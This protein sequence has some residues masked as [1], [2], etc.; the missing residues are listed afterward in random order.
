MKLCFDIEY[1]TTWGEE[2]RVLG[3][4]PELGGESPGE[5]LPL[6]TVDGI[7]WQGE[8]EAA[9]PCKRE[10][11]YL[12]QIY[13]DGK[14]VRTEWHA[15][16]RTLHLHDNEGQ[17]YRLVD[18]WKDLPE[19]ACF[20]TSAFT[21]SLLAR[22]KSGVPP[23]VFKRG[24]QVKA[25]APCIGS[26]YVLGLCG[27]QPALGNWNADRALLMNDACFPEWQVALDAQGLRYPLEYKFVLYSLKTRRAV[28]WEEGSNR[29]LDEP[30]LG[31]NEMLVIGD[32]YPCFNLPAWK[33]AGVTVPVFSL[34][35]KQS[36]GVG[37]FGDLK[38]L[39]DWAA[40]TGQQVVQILPVNDTTL[41]HTWSDS[42]PYNG[43]S[44]YALHPMY[45]DLEQVGTLKDEEAM[46]RFRERREALNALPAVD[47]EAVNKLKW[48][49]FELIFR[50]EGEA[51]LASKAFRSFYDTNREWL[52][53]YAAF[54]YLR[55][56]YGTPDFHRWPKYGEYRQ[57]EIAPLCSIH[58][59][60]YPRLS[61]YYYIQYHL[62]LQLSAAS[63][64]ARAKGVVLK[65]D[66]PIG[67][68]RDSVEAWVEPFYFNMNGQAGAPPDD[69]S[70]NGQNWGFPTYN[71]EVM[72]RDGY[73][74][75]MKRFRKMAGYFDAYRID[76]ILGFFRIWEIPMHAVH[77]LM[78]QFSPALPLSVEEI[79]T[80]GLTFRK[81]FLHPY[82]H[83]AFL[84]ALFG[85]QTEKVKRAFLEPTGEPGVYRM[86]P[87]FETQRKVEAWFADRQD[88]ESLRVRDGLY[89]LISEVLF[90]PDRKDPRLYH[91]R[92]GVQRDYVFRSLTVREQMAF[93][94]LYEHYFYH[95]HNDFWRE[96]AMRKLPQL[97]EA[98][99]MLVCGE[100]L[101]MIPDCVPWVMHDLRIL[102]LE[103]QR[104]PKEFG[105]AFG[106]PERYPYRSVCTISTHD[107]ST[108]RGWWEE[109]YPQ[110]QRY[111]NEVLGHEGVAPEVAT[112]ELCEEVIRQHLQGNSMLCILSLQDW[113]SI[114]GERRN[115][116]V[117]QERIN[118]PAN[119]H[120]YW[121]YRMHLTLEALMEAGD[122]NR[123][124]KELIVESGRGKVS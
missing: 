52:Q 70:T 98:T 93:N 20:Y 116:D 113:L 95:R 99:R 6:H 72:A 124:I 55:D 86:R 11:H 54:S 50:Q 111:Y 110:I 117:G 122:L 66:I 3:D 40:A 80:Y 106:H 25:Y 9:L 61:L 4:I 97:T 123:R 38:R 19:Q 71:W 26:G 22:R 13:R 41:T 46:K 73:S 100:D 16:P 14:A 34:R 53:P 118:V 103:I 76:H 92:I 78:G 47:Y 102:S 17:V 30:W 31:E 69:F 39:V 33:G 2:V 74:W 105:Q 75:W 94:R 63:A 36:Y 84:E 104:M 5:A 56:V 89:T 101:G 62:H 45:A 29:R 35:S 85:M 44:I 115:P 96:Q 81:E 59:E 91:P 10:L 120:N 119:P 90:L 23:I 28:A 42:Y 79:A 82:I 1:R 49:Y 48:E 112:P 68:S 64:H 67:I 83:D 24:L 58:S 88:E 32:R 109:D 7:R 8:V 18:D 107:M 121:R 15:L 27:N 57:K 60:A 114:D 77:G 108:L 51:V 37:D 21:E 87:G 65:G 12:Y 43:I